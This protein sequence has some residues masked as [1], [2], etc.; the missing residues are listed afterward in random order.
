MGI[1]HPDHPTT[2]RKGLQGRRCSCDECDYMSPRR[3]RGRERSISAPTQPG[4]NASAPTEQ[5]AHQS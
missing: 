5:R 4:G 1:Y 3:A 2:C